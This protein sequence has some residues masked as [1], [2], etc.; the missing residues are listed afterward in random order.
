[1]VHDISAKL[2]LLLFCFNAAHSLGIVA[3]SGQAPVDGYCVAKIAV[4]TSNL[5]SGRG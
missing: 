2:S 3:R 4:A 1:M 5:G